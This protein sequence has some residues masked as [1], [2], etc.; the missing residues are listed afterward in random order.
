M[1]TDYSSAVF[2]FAYLRR[3]VVYCQF[4]REQ[5]FSGTHVYSAGYFDYDRDGFGPVTHDLDATVGELI[6]QMENG[7]RVDEMYRTRM[8]SFFAFNDKES[9]RRVTERILALTGRTAER[10]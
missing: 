6:R 9:S 3:P 10:S 8:D 7:F 2:D 1:V 4:D 5:F